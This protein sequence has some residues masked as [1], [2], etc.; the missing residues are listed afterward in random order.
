VPPIEPDPKITRRY[1][2]GASIRVI[3]K[4]IG[5]SD[6]YVRSRLKAAN[7][8]LRKPGGG[9]PAACRARWEDIAPCGTVSAAQ[10]HRRRGE[11]IDPECHQAELAYRRARRQQKPANANAIEQFCAAR[12]AAFDKAAAELAA[13]QRLMATWNDTSKPAEETR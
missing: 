1:G 13:A 4:E 7:V 2:E 6:S 3:A 9:W 10:R 5:R 12:Q 8:Q 11:P